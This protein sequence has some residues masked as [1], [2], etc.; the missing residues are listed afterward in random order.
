[1]ARLRDLPPDQ[2]TALLFASLPGMTYRDVA[3]RL[4]EDPVVVRRQL[5][6][7]LRALRS[8]GQEV[9]RQPL[10]Q[11]DG[12]VERLDVHPLVLAMEAGPE[13]RRRDLA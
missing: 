10:P 8:S 3:A 1:M 9:A 2:A 4:G 13:L 6:D 11:L 12:Q 5:T 7:G